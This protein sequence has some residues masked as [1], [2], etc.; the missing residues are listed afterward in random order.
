M[1]VLLGKAKVP[2]P[3]LNGKFF[4]KEFYAEVCIR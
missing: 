4:N 1:V 3:P 2:A